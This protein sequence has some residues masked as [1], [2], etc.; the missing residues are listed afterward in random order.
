MRYKDLVQ[1]LTDW[2]QLNINFFK[3]QLKNVQTGKIEFEYSRALLPELVKN[4]S[5]VFFLS[6][7][8]CGTKYIANLLQENRF[9]D[10]YHH[11]FPE[12]LFHQQTA[13]VNPHSD[14]TKF[15][16]EA[17]RIELIFESIRR[18]RI[19]V[20]TNNR[21]TFFA[22]A[23][24]TIFPKARF[25]HLIRHPIDFINSGLKRNWYSQKVIADAGRIV[26]EDHNIKWDLFEPFEKIA[27]LW[28]TTNQFIEDFKSQYAKQTFTFNSEDLF[29]NTNSLEELIGL[30][31]NEKISRKMKKKFMKP[32]NRQSKISSEKI[33][34]NKDNLPYQVISKAL[35][36]KYH[37]E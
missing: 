31:S 20:E 3:S 7:G 18:N 11:A 27:W 15:V 6:T 12:L 4:Y 1:S 30:I 21:L 24:A 37:I 14:E 29:T 33:I 19:Y 13:Y 16:I 22:Y 8:R 23:L 28:Y 35:L 26:P 34:L 36:Y 2:K 9:L 32:I 10:V 25:V 5:P 17:A